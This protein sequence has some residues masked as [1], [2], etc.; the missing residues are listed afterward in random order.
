VSRNQDGRL[1][2]FARGT[3][4]ALWHKWQLAP[5]SG[6]SGWA[7]EGGVISGGTDDDDLFAAVRNGNFDGDNA[8]N[9]N[10]TEIYEKDVM[11]D[12][13]PDD[14]QIRLTGIPSSDVLNLT[15]DMTL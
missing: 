12:G 11:A 2:V 4:G 6:W 9:I 10:K 3:D 1:E 13:W 7:S 8:N 15:N 14:L 5:N